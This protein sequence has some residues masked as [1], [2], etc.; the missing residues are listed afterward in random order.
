[1]LYFRNLFKESYKEIKNV[2]CIT[3]TAMLGAVSI[4]L[5]SLRLDITNFLRI[6]FSF[7][8]NQFVY[9]M[10]GPTV[11]GV[12]GAAIDILTFILKPSGVF[13]PGITFNAVL[14]GIIYG[15]VLYKRPF[16]L[17][18]VLI[19]NVIQMIIVN[20]I[21]TTYWLTDLTGS[22]FFALFPP[23]ALKSL[24][25]LPIETILF[26]TTVKALEA[27]GIKKLLTGKRL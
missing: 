22:S 10:F 26:F 6:G 1:M 2:R 23:R 27:A 4:V 16:S 24:I 14:T 9:Y 3:V 5:G 20:L 25:M 8:P 11:G 19:A 18:R 21:L 17:K 13:H 7:L 12:Y 15:L